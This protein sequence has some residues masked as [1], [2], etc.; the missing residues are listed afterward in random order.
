[1]KG[2][3]EPT[4]R[5]QI[6]D[7]KEWKEEASKMSKNEKYGNRERS[8]RRKEDGKEVKDMKEGHL[9]SPCV[10]YLNVWNNEK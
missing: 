2:C 6:C 5:N 10:C 1:M 7:R 3:K 8:D 4:C 9:H